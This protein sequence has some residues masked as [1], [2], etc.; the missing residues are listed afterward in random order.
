MYVHPE[1]KTNGMRATTV[2]LP[3]F[4]LDSS[5]PDGGRG[6]DINFRAPRATDVRGVSSA[7]EHL[8]WN[9]ITDLDSASMSADQCPRHIYIQNEVKS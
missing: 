1:D 6:P 9:V 4:S 7:L 8:A 2:A 5:L 3:A